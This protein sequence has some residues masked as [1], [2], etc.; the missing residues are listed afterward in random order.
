MSK[1][2]TVE[3]V[4]TRALLILPAI[5]IGKIL[6]GT[7][8]NVSR[9]V[10]V[11]ADHPLDNSFFVQNNLIVRFDLLGHLN[12]LQGWLELAG[13]CLA[14]EVRPYYPVVYV[15]WILFCSLPNLLNSLHI[16]LPL[17]QSKCPMTMTVMC[18]RQKVLCHITNSNTF[19]ILSSQVLDK[20][21][22]LISEGMFWIVHETPSEA[23]FWVLVLCVITAE[24][25]EAKVVVD[26]TCEFLATWLIDQSRRHLLG[27]LVKRIDRRA[28]PAHL[29]HSDAKIEVSFAYVGLW[30]VHLCLRDLGQMSPLLFLHSIQTFFL[31][32]AGWDAAI[33]LRVVWNLLRQLFQRRL[34]H[35][36]HAFF[37]RADTSG[38][39]IR[40]ASG[41][42][43]FIWEH[44]D[45]SFLHK[46]SFL[47]TR[48]KFC[49]SFLTAFV[50]QCLRRFALKWTHRSHLNLMRLLRW[51]KL[52]IN[53]HRV[54][55]RR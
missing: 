28:V 8:A 46:A 31:K 54:P 1:Y 24:V 13:V 10:F 23:L 44:I 36:L 3:I 17:H 42:D 47:L 53:W 27:C 9:N 29:I 50:K 48:S 16:P 4:A 55:L 40:N 45:M 2:G 14:E 41:S 51:Q 7:Q 5:L 33:H 15:A 22:I 25:D 6:F 12:L 20:S 39:V 30:L 19:F 11:Q 35:K 49:Q 21:Q 26:L 38:R 52:R 37:A 43:T 34:P 18:F 32:L